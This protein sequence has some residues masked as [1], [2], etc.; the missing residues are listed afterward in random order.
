MLGGVTSMS[1][2]R[3]CDG[4]APLL[5]SASIHVDVAPGEGFRQRYLRI[6]MVAE[7]DGMTERVE[8]ATLLF[9]RSKS[10]TDMGFS[11]T[12][13]TGRSVLWPAS[14]KRLLAGSYAPAG[15]N[16]AEWAG[17]MLSEVLAAPVSVDGG[18][19]LDDQVTFKGGTSV[20]AAAWSVLEAG[21]FVMQIDGH[22]TVHVTPMPED[23]SLELGHANARLLIPG[24]SRDIDTSEVPNHYVAVDG[25]QTAE[26]TN[27]DPT[28]ETSTV[29]R[30]YVDDGDSPDTSP[31]RVN[32]E[33][34][35]AYCARML[36]EKSVV[37]DVRQYR[38]EY[39]PGVH[40][41]SMVRGTMPSVELEGDLRVRRQSLTLG[42][43]IVVEER[44]E[45]EV[46]TWQRP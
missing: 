38:R 32:G 25:D 43:G 10:D 12:E 28:S 17:S 7:Q 19:T 36:E 35:A 22:G 18:F 15:V 20:L 37:K 4:S 39:W 34:L 40:P 27:D 1:V 14:R 30:G 9:A 8:V 11:D 42:R 5:E 3:D 46:R 41:Y 26:A 24:V 13:L 33:T 44:A 16:G 2:T 23:P 31:K 29:A 6:V 45:A 21:G